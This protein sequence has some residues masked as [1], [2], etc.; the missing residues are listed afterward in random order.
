[1]LVVCDGNVNAK[2]YINILNQGLLLAFHS[3]KLRCHS[4]LFMQDR[5]PCHTA[6]KT[7]DWLAKE[8]IKCLPWPSQ[9]PDIN[10]IENPW[11]ILD[12]ALQKP[13]TKPSS[14]DLVNYLRSAWAEIPQETIAKL[15]KTM[16]ERLQAL[17]CSKGKSS[18]Y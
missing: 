8:G 6:K 11:A 12:R 18:R 9:S 4:T 17:R 14:K 15:I 16:P 13:P 3:G 7:K 2:K 1:M 5:D 10:P